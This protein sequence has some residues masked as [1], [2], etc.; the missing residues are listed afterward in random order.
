MMF[1]TN[2]RRFAKVKW[3]CETC[4]RG[5]FKR[6]DENRELLELLQHQAPGFLE[7][8]PWVERWLGDQ[9]NFLVT[10]ANAVGTENHNAAAGAEF[11]RKWPGGRQVDGISVDLTQLSTKVFQ[12]ANTEMFEK[13]LERFQEA[14]PL[15]GYGFSRDRSLVVEIDFDAKQALGQVILKEKYRFLAPRFDSRIRLKQAEAEL[16]DVTWVDSV[17]TALR[18]E[19]V[20][21]VRLPGYPAN[22]R[23][24]TEVGAS[25]KTLAKDLDEAQRLINDLLGDAEDKPMA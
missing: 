22:E 24:S 11:P 7:Q 19:G 21:V 23:R 20:F 8:H 6:I 25:G 3:I 10:L 2:L 5:I 12:R 13:I 18:L 15:H 16:E 14:A 1:M 4:Y 17:V 9:D